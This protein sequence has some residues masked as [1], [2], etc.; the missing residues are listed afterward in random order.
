MYISY[1]YNEFLD[2]LKSEKNVSIHTTTSYTNDFNQFINFLK[3]NGIQP[4]LN[5]ITTPIIRR[6]IAYLKCEKEFSIYTIRR[7]IH[8]LSSYFKFLIEQGYLDKN[9][10][11]SIH[12]PKT[13][14]VVPKYLSIEE[15]KLLLEAPAKYSPEHALRNKVILETLIYTG[16]RRQELLGLNWEDIDFGEKTITIK[17]GKGKKQRVVPLKEPLLSDLWKYL[18][19]RLPLTNQA[20][21]ISSYGN[22]LSITAL[23]QM[24]RRY[25]KILGFDKKG[26]TLHTLRHTYASHLALNGV[27]I[28]SIQKLL[29]HSD[30]G[31]TQVYSHVNTEHL[32]K[33]IEKLPF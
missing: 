1:Y 13:P 26:Y 27:S 18:Q 24:F 16:M 22:R 20:V 7:R 32:K 12:A 33:E 11:L 3:L 9:P 5:T 28:L 31:S 30:L 25:M 6:Y 4:K 19:S 14:E 23:Q 17:K 29:G 8:S 21:F 15:I 10:M 2:Y